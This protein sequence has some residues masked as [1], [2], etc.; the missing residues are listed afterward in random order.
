MFSKLLQILQLGAA[1]PF[2]KGMNIIDIAHDLACLAGEFL[3]A[4]PSQIVGGNN[5]PVNIRHAGCYEALELELVFAFRNFDRAHFA[6]PVINVLEEM[7]VDRAKMREI[8]IAG[9]NPFAGALY[10]EPPFHCI[11]PNSVDDA[12][13]VDETTSAGIDVRI[14]AHSAASGFALER[15]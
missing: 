6:G 11:E 12:E 8:K 1:V 15:M 7:L 10:Y 13:L 2:A 14:V 9:G 3:C 4:Q 5:P